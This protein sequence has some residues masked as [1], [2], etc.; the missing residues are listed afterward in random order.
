MV[1]E[2][3][4]GTHHATF[5]LTGDSLVDGDDL[6]AWLA[7]AGG[8]GGLTTTGDPILLGDANLDGTVDG[9]DFLAWNANKFQSDGG[10]CGGDFNADGVVDGSDFL[11]WNDNK[12]QS[13]DRGGTAV[14]E[15][16]GLSLCLALAFARGLFRGPR[17]GDR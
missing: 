1:A 9:S 3:A 7:E 15:P 8:I 16:V 4:A 6:L 12:F 10:W 11:I 2:I 5:D 14:P 13:A 17:I